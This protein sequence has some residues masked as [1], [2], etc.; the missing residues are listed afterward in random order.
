MIKVLVVDDSRFMRDVISKIIGE[1]KELKVVGRAKNGKN[2]ID[3]NEK[4]DP[5]VITMD[6]EMPKMNGVEAVK[7]IME[8]NPTP[9]VMISSV[10]KRGAD[11]TIESLRHGA[12]DFIEK[13]E[14]ID[15][16][17]KSEE[18]VKKV[19]IASKAKIEKEVPET[20]EKDL[21]EIKKAERDIIVIG[22]S[23]GGPKAL[24]TIFSSLPFVSEIKGI[25][26]Q[27]MP[28]KFTNRLAKRLDSVSE[29]N[30]NEAENNAPLKPG[31]FLLAPGGY[32]LTIDKDRVKLNQDPKIN[33]VRPSV[34]PAMATASKEYKNRLLGVILTGM[35]KDGLMGSK[36]IIRNDGKIIAQN[37][38][39]CQVYG[40]PK[41]VIESGNVNSIVPLD[42]IPKE[43]LKFIEGS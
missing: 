28:S 10:T 41:R 34:D 37:K 21:P 35:G 5:D 12:V 14:G 18:I 40:M 4:L 29:Y 19:K 32:H 27:H 2:A 15:I 16:W 23:T 20:T 43:I 1:D 11:S 38:E 3:M 7:E 17:K 42:K 30:I 25:I 24:E 33:N 36:E 13:S 6:V 22:S 9:I 31:S 26:V 8:S 39:S